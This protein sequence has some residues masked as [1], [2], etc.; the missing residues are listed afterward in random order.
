MPIVH[1][2]KALFKELGDPKKIEIIRV[3]YSTSGLNFVVHDNSSPSKDQ[4]YR[5]GRRRDILFRKL[6]KIEKS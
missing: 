3:I 2:K 1:D 6:D 5:I 4:R